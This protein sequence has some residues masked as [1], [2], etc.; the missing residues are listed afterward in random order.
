MA[1]G[2]ALEEGK[3]MSLPDVVKMVEAAEMGKSTH[4]QISKAGGLYRMSD[5]RKK[6]QGARIKKSRQSGQSGQGRS[7]CGFCGRSSHPR[8]EC[9]AREQECNFCK[10]KGHFSVK[11]RKKEKDKDKKKVAEIKEKEEPQSSLNTLEV[12]ELEDDVS[13]DVF[14]LSVSNDSVSATDVPVL[15]VIN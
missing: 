7:S 8:D 4:A 11:C 14:Q 13:A 3:E 2:A 6:Q 12:V 1:A 10:M 9:P 5:H 15:G